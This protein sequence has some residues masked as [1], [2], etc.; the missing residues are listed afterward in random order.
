MGISVRRRGTET[1]TL[2]KG[3]DDTCLSVCRW[4]M[5]RYENSP[6]SS[7]K[8]PA[9]LQPRVLR[10][11]VPEDSNLPC[12]KATFSLPF[13]V[14]LSILL[15]HKPLTRRSIDRSIYPST[16]ACHN[17]HSNP[18]AWA[19]HSTYPP[20]PYTSSNSHPSASDD[21]NPSPPAPASP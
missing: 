5:D 21:S 1:V 2:R 11:H 14:C 16:S 7:C 13:P 12:L 6:A 20:W 9:L 15:L 18:P 4:Y 8:C 19:S 10:H 17:Q 3:R